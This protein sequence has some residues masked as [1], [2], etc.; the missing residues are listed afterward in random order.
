KHFL[1]RLLVE[2]VQP[3]RDLVHAP[4]F[5]SLHAACQF[6]GRGVLQT[7]HRRLDRHRGDPP[8][9]LSHPAC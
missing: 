7:F 4:I 1:A 2:G 9:Y 8:A 3:Q 5:S 6:K